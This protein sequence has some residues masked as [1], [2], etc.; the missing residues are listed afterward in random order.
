MSSGGFHVHGPHDHEL[1]H[2][3]QGADSG[4]DGGDDRNLRDHAAAAF[5]AGAMRALRRVLKFV[6]VGA[7]YVKSA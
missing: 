5:M 2:A 7:V 4:N 6:V 3:A 1:E